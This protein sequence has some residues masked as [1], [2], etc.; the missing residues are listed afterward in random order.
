M[1]ELMNAGNY[2]FGFAFSFT[3]FGFAIWVQALFAA[4]NSL[5]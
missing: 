2:N 1:M 5:S 4:Q 3:F